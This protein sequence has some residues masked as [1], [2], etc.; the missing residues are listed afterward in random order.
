MKPWPWIQAYAEDLG[1]D[2]GLVLVALISWKHAFAGYGVDFYAYLPALLLVRIAGPWLASGW[3]FSVEA[4]GLGTL[5]REKGGHGL[6]MGAFCQFLPVEAVN[7][8][9]AQPQ[10]LVQDVLWAVDVLLQTPAL[11]LLVLL[12]WAW[13]GMVGR[14]RSKG[15][16]EPGWRFLVRALW[17]WFG[18]I[19][20]AIAVWLAGDLERQREVECSPGTRVTITEKRSEYIAPSKGSSRIEHWITWVS[21]PRDAGNPSYNGDW[22]EL[23]ESEWD[24]LQ[25]GDSVELGLDAQGSLGLKRKSLYWEEISENDNTGAPLFFL[26]FGMPVAWAVLLLVGR[27]WKRGAGPRLLATSAQDGQRP[28]QGS[29][30]KASEP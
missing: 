2:L 18:A 26:F 4:P 29:P 11:A 13:E 20:L 21:P 12:P 9:C 8:G 10:T 1:V 5:L 19:W 14:S 24:A 27:R 25:V 15:A 30:S 3:P 28:S 7:S 16:E 22:L 23:D 6:V 17:W